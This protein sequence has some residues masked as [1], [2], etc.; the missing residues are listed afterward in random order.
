MRLFV[1]ALLIIGT[2]R[3][4][5]GLVGSAPV[6][7]E[8]IWRPCA[9]AHKRR[10]F[11]LLKEGFVKEEP[12]RK[13]RQIDDGFRRLN[14]R[15]AVFNFLHDYY[16]V[17]GAKGTR[18]LGRWAPGRALVTLEGAT[19]ADLDNAILSRVGCEVHCGGVTYDAEKHF[20]SAEPSA[21]TPFM[22]YHSLLSSTAKAEPI[23]HCYNLH[24]WAMQYWPAGAAP[25]P[26]QRYQADTMPLRVTQETINSLIERKG[27][28][29]THV[30]ALRFF[31]PAA[32][33]LNRAFVLTCDLCCCLSNPF[34]FCVCV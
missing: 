9:E 24:E 34:S 31:A 20:R 13:E 18:R 25:P 4:S 33:P 16:N 12:I 23:L 27:V 3:Q 7:A 8:H 21:A 10:V 1:S 29:C 19:Q 5:D 11:N 2:V 22:W 26:S 30:D 14:E 32:G 15:N 17:R 28:R 6:L